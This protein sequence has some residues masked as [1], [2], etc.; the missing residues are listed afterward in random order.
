MSP[1]PSPDR[2]TQKPELTDEGLG[3]AFA[4]NGI[5]EF[6]ETIEGHIAAERA[7][8]IYLN[9]REI[10][11]LMTL[12]TQ[13]ELLV[14]GWLR[15][16]RLVKNASDIRAIQVDWETESVAVT[17]HD[18][19]DGIDEKLS[20]KTVTTGCGQGTVYGDMMDGLSQI[21]LPKVSLRQSRIYELLATLNKHNEIYKKAGAVHG[22][23]LCQ[24]TENQRF[25][26]D[27]GRHN[28]VDAIA[29]YMWLHDISG[30]DKIFYTTGRLTSEMVIK[31]AQMGIPVLLSRSGATQM[32]Y[33]IAKQ[34]GVVLISRAKGKHFLVYN[35]AENIEF[36]AIP[37]KITSKSNT[38]S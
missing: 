31:V 9:K 20:K 28:A 21:Q 29:G 13:P 11:T 35:G 30:G 27:V 6:G 32:G 22:C 34:L 36:D 14:L 8:T 7:L 26:E 19:I 17:T 4:V 23:A 18:A 2:T 15:N 16:Q 12:G 5:N 25:V 24:D 33:E 1:T 10:V 38:A 3:A 37:N